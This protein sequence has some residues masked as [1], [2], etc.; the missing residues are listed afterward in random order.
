MKFKLAAFADEADSRLAGQ[1]SAMKENGVD[2]L[3]I[4][5]IDGENISDIKTAK[6]KEI[7]KRL[8][9]AGIS[10][11]SLGSPYGKIGITE[12][13]EPHLEK[14]KYGLEF[15]NILS[16]KH[17][18]IFSFY[19]PHN[20]TEHY[21]SEVMRRLEK[22]MAAAKESDVML[23]HENEKG[24]YGDNAERC[25]EIHKNI[26]KLRAVFD[27]AN[28]V[29]CGQDTK[30]AWEQLSPYV[31]YL[32]I[33]DAN[34]DGSVVPAGKGIGNI[35]YI[36]RNYHGEILTVEPHLSVFSGFEKLECGETAE[37]KY[38]YPDSRT[39]F[40]AAVNALK[41]ILEEI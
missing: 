11:W 16:A 31:E 22:M 27:P 38:R 9:D 26:P 32:H 13:F 4:R 33:K 3:E 39:A 7:K 17:I 5:S 12:D 37:H 34:A 25:A 41:E 1:I 23:C 35:P 29:Q 6:A 10:V 20:D 14:F 15:A 40:N 24:I 21:S 8:D 30:S 36:L 19:V 2:Y 28:F 18:R